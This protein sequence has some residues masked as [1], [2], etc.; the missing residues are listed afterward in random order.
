[1]EMEVEME[2]KRIQTPVHQIVLVIVRVIGIAQVGPTATVI[3]PVVTG[4][5]MLMVL[6]TEEDVV[7]RREVGV[8]VVL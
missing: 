3:P 4:L 2:S 1:M 7:L 6:G 8:A 5:R